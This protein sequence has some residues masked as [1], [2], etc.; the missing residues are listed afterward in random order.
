[1]WCCPSC[2]HAANFNDARQPWPQGWTCGACNFVVP[3]SDGIPCLAPE[4]AD[5]SVGFD[6]KLFETLAGLEERNFWF[7][8]RARLIASL[9][10]KHFPRSR[11]FLEIGCGTG[12]VL[13]ALCDARPQL[14]LAGSELHCRGLAF[15]R[16]RLGPDALLLQMDARK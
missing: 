6:P 11:N 7:V 16:R 4:L 8:N 3:H 1:M 15:A 10:R 5:T 14:T 12:S 9:L 2:R 13:L